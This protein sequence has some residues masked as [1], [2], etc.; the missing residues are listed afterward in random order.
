MV[1]SNVSIVN[2]TDCHIPSTIGE[3]DVGVLPLSY[4]LVVAMPRDIDH[5]LSIW[6]DTLE[7]DIATDIG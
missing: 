1:V 4:L 2:G 3:V 5:G 7:R 6:R